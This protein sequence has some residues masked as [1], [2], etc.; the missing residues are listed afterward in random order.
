MNDYMDHFYPIWIKHSG[1]ILSLM[2]PHYPPNKEKLM[3]VTLG[4]GKNRL[5]LEQQFWDSDTM[6]K[7]RILCLNNSELYWTGSLLAKF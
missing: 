6:K 7:D 3:G 2:A 5:K 4:Q 1:V